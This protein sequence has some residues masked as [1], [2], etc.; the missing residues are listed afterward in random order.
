MS[1]SC[2]FPI[3]TIYNIFENR[4]AIFRETIN[5]CNDVIYEGL[6]TE[7]HFTIDE[8]RVRL[9]VFI[10]NCVQNQSDFLF[11]DEFEYHP[12]NSNR[13]HYDENFK[14]GDESIESLTKKEILFNMSPYLTMTLIIGG[15][16]KSIKYAIS[17]HINV[18]NKDINDLIEAIMRSV[19]HGY[20]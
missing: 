16:S 15:I 10:I 11:I 13:H 2:G 14:L 9:K 7:D 4:S 17:N 5:Y 20:M 8:L 1:D 18:T 19:V 6:K 12:L 3:G